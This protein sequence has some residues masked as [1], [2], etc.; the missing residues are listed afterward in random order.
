MRD[1]V[2]SRIRSIDFVMTGLDPNRVHTRVFADET[3]DVWV[4]VMLEART[5]QYD[6]VAIVGAM[7]VEVVMAESY[8][9]AHASLASEVLALFT[10]RFEV[11]RRDD[12]WALLDLVAQAD[13][14]TYLDGDDWSARS[15]VRSAV[16]EADALVSYNDVILRSPSVPLRTMPA[17]VVPAL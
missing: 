9:Q 7:S 2:V 16:V 6:T 8:A 5:L 4:E 17:V 12:D 14:R 15:A 1:D 10:D 3:G 13:V 11:I